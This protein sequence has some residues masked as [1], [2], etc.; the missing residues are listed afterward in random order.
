MFIPFAIMT[1]LLLIF[2]WGSCI[3][4][5]YRFNLI[6]GRAWGGYTYTRLQEIKN[7]NNVDI[8]FLGSSHTYRGFDTRLFANANFT[9]FNLGTTSQTPIQAELLLHRYLKHINPKMAI[10]EIYPEIFTSDGV[11]SSVDIIGNSK[12]DP[13]ALKMA[14]KI[15][16]IKT[17]NTLLY[18]Y[19]KDFLYPEISNPEPVQ[20]GYDTYISGGYVE[21]KVEYFKHLNYPNAEWIYNQKQFDSFEKVCALLKSENIRIILIYAPITPSLYNSYT[22]Q[23]EFDKKMSGYGDYYNFNEIIHL[24]DSLYFYDA[25]HLNQKGVEIFNKKIIEVVLNNQETNGLK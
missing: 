10:F 11:E 1:Y 22:N 13:E 25:D 14:I 21:R 8:L 18:S 2:I 7:A 15:N 24:D 23:K 3:P 20:T 4:Q 12:N 9:S 19:M 17:Y 5:R 16:N 6:Y